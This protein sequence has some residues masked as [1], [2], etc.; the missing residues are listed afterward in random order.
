[1]KLDIKFFTRFIFFISTFA[2]VLGKKSFFF[3]WFSKED[4]GP[5]LKN[6]ESENGIKIIFLH[7]SI[8][9]N[10]WEGGVKEWFKNYNKK[11]KVNYSIVEQVFPK[12]NP[13]GW[14]NYPFD[15]WNI[16][17]KHSGD[18]AYK[19]EPTLEMITNQYDV[20]VLKHCFPVGNI[21]E[22]TGKSNVSCEVKR[23]ENYKVQYEALRE[24]MNKFNQ[25][26]FIVWT[27]PALVEKK[28]SKEK[29]SRAKEFY[30]WMKDEWNQKDDNIYL[31]DFYKLE[32]EGDLYL[33]NKYAEGSE[34]SHP[35][36]AFSEKIAPYFCQRIVDIIEDRGDNSCLIGVEK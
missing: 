10:I 35:N 18:E 16:W 2:M 34:N 25:T 31:W 8:G 5:I 17:V 32:T 27:I 4:T 9:K 3:K 11:N 36:K 22:D 23:L 30:K 29:A 15:Y 20:I 12:K 6:P 13:Y 1:M 26:K 19:K 33:K 14:K 21:D 28:T 24:K 7:H